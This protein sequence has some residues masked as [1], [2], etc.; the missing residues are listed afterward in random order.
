MSVNS[1]MTAIA[2][3]IR[4]KTGGTTPLTLDQMATEINNIGVG[5][6]LPE[7]TN[8]GTA[9]DLMKG[10]QMISG[11]GVAVTGSFTLDSELTEQDSLIE[12]IKTALAGKAAGGGESTPTQEKTVTISENGTVEV[13]PDEGYALSKVTANVNVPIP[14]GYIQ[15]SGTLEITENGE[16]DVT[17]K[18]SVVV[19]VESGGGGDPTLPDG[20]VRCGYIQFNGDQIVD[21]GIICNQNSKLKFVFTREKS[22]A[23]YMFGVASED[24]TAALT[25]YLG[26]NWRF[27][28]K[29]QS[30]SPIA[31]EDMIYG[32]VISSSE[33]T[34]TSA[35][36]AISG[37]NEFETIGTLLLGT[38]RNSNGTIPSA[39]F[40]G[41]IYSFIM[42]DGNTEVLHLVPVVSL[43]GVYRFY[44]TVN[45][46]FLDS[47]TDV[48]L[49]GGNL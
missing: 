24:N 31:N 27:G 18:A 44:D 6:D 43:D 38:C 41:K 13:T 42:W 49:E 25:A 8:E 14:E 35:K 23:H 37:V 20:Y 12:Q 15:P 33:I 2:D 39:V 5:V 1:K 10:K 26:G 28:N 22:T 32:G 4:G 11:A 48:P 46:A 36:T 45:G 34:I 9:S 16:Y 17:E 21:T 30:K 40:V 19:A 7:L 47:I 29:A 3:A